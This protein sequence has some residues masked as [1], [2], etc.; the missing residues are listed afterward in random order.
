MAHPE[1]TR[2]LICIRSDGEMAADVLGDQCSGLYAWSV[3]PKAVRELG[4][5]FQMRLLTR[6]DRC[7][8]PPRR[9]GTRLRTAGHNTRKQ[10]VGQPVLPPCIVTLSKRCEHINTLTMCW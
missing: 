4:F 8:R 10:A 2:E 7:I 1:K 6:V 9:H 3:I 5:K